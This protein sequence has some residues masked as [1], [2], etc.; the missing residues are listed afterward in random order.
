MLMNKFEHSRTV[1]ISV[2]VKMCLDSATQNAL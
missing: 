2:D 1:L